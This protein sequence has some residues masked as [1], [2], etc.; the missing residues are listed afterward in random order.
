MEYEGQICRAPM[1]RASYMLPVMVGCSY[2]KCKFC[3]LFRHLTFRVIP[4]EMVEQDLIRVKKTGGIP[5]K[6]FFGDGNAFSLPSDYLLQLLDLVHKYFPDCNEINMDATVTSIL[7]KTDAQLKALYDNSVRHLYLGIESGLDDVLRFMHKDHTLPQA[8][9]AIA[10]LHQ[11]GFYFDAHIMTGV[12]GA[13]RGIENAR[14]LAEFLNKTKPSRVVNFS[15]FLHREVPLA[16]HL[17]DGSFTPADE[18]QNL[19]EDRCLIELLGDLDTYHEILYDSFHDFIEF[20]VK[21][22]LP[23]D[24]TKMLTKI[25]KIIE[26][27]KERP[28]VYSMVYGEC[29]NVF[30]ENTAAPVWDMN[31]KEGV[32]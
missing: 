21:G 20:R 7:N 1:E 32:S 11:F 2:N 19:L 23:E 9:E 25:D 8:Y 24:R 29:P 22:S 17:A 27:Y 18:Y 15:M 4:L 16:A 30:R 31:A 13:G 3:N 6:I 26:I 10:R 12:A 28:P 14:A 5:R